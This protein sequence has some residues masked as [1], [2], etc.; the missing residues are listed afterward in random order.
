MGRACTAIAMAALLTASTAAAQ[1]APS[2]PTLTVTPA[3]TSRWDTYGHLTWLGKHQ[4]QS[5]D[6]WYEVATGGATVGYYWTPHLKAELD[7]S[8][9]TQG[10]THSIEP[11]P[12]F[13]GLPTF[14]TSEHEFRLT[15]VAAA[16]NAQ[17][18][19]NTWFHPFAGA[20]IEVTRERENVTRTSSSVIP[21]DPRAPPTI[22]PPQ[23]ETKTRYVGRP[24]VSAGFKVYVSE[25]AF[26]RT[27]LRTSWSSDGL[28][29][30]AWRNGI[31]FD[32]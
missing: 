24:F 11:V 6:P 23:T 13:P 7:V 21:R 10:R 30:M 17:F 19:E 15:T 8:T 1:D 29:A 20:G 28:A 2:R 31:G 27:D 22:S 16:F 26:I 5:F 12:P 18:F 4:Y 14:V 32:F 9:S 25:R 3:D